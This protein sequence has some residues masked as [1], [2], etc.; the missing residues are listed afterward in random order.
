MTPAPKK[1]QMEALAPVSDH[2]TN[3]ELE[4][5]VIESKLRTI[6]SSLEILTSICAKLPD[7]VVPEESPGTSIIVVHYK[8]FMTSEVEKE[9][10]V[11]EEEETDEVSGAL[12]DEDDELEMEDVPIAPKTNG[13]DSSDKAKNY[14]A[15]VSSL[16]QPLLALSHPTALSFPPPSTPP[17]HPPTTSALGTIHVRALECLNNL[18]LGLDFDSSSLPSGTAE[19][20]TQVWLQVWEILRAVGVQSEWTIGSG[21]DI[22][23]DMWDI[24][25]GV[26]WGLSKLANGVL[27][28]TLW[29]RVVSQLKVLL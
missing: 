13:P 17:I 25:V 16:T 3:T 5:E 19:Q 20:V 26:L 28:R 22:K 14:L 2:K 18:F 10:E 7:P 9:E 23:K 24:G 21:V 11:M 29:H 15:L 1:G 6:A 4:L 12:E 27:V 8:H